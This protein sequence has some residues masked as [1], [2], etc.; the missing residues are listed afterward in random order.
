MTTVSLL[1]SQEYCHSIP[2]TKQDL[3]QLLCEMFGRAFTTSSAVTVSFDQTNTLTLHIPQ[4]A[5][6]SDYDISFDIDPP[7]VSHC[8]LS[9]VWDDYYYPYRLREVKL[10]LWRLHM[11][12][13]S[14]LE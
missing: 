14:S 7:V 13:E 12:Q 6:I 1:H 10:M 2:Y 9:Y 3:R 4:C 5:N 11:T 8:I